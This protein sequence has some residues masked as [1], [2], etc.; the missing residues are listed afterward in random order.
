MHTKGVIILLATVTVLTAVVFTWY[1]NQISSEVGTINVAHKEKTQ[2]LG[3]TI[4][5][6][7]ANPVADQVP[8]TNVMSTVVVNPFD[9]YKNPFENQ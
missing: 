3:G 5:D 1:N 4:Y 9:T 7:G 8:E 6:K 2:S